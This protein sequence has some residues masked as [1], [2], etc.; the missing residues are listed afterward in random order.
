[1]EEAEPKKIESLNMDYLDLLPLAKMLGVLDLK[2]T[3]S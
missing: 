3:T 2:E 1:M